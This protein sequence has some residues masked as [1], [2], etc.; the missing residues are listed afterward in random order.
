M[1][2]PLLPLRLRRPPVRNRL[3]AGAGPRDWAT[4]PARSARSSR[5]SWAGWRAA[6]SSAVEQLPGCGPRQALRAY[7][8]LELL[9]LA[10][11]LALPLVLPVAAGLLAGGYGDG[12]TP[13]FLASTSR[14]LLR[15]RVHSGGSHGRH[16]SDRNSRHVR[17]RRVLVESE[18]TLYAANTVG[19]ALGAAATGFV[20][21]PALGALRTV[22]IGA[23]LNLIGGSR[24][25]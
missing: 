22:S 25:D 14:R 2:F 1:L 7:A 12:P 17:Q 5:R 3:V 10:A 9:V 16:V 24:R 15:E 13:A 6:R 18:G 23:L 20:F 4:A 19:A 8:S 21:L 11:A